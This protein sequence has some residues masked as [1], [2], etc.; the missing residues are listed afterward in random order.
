VLNGSA[1]P[2]FGAVCAGNVHWHG[3]IRHS[4]GEP[5]TEKARSAA[6]T[7]RGEAVMATVYVPVDGG[8]SSF[9]PG[10]AAA[11]VLALASLLL[12]GVALPAS[13]DDLGPLMQVSRG[14]P[15]ADCTADKADKQEGILYRQTAIE[16]WIDANPAD[17]QNLIAGWQQDRWSNGGSRGNIAGVSQN[18]G[19]TWHNVVLPDHRL[20]GRQVQARERSLG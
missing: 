20:H 10:S 17:G 18:G 6:L 15:F 3:P 4:V 1:D 2:R 12:A 5:K 9:R 13:A 14:N 19:N 11:A 16:P 8:S 7:K